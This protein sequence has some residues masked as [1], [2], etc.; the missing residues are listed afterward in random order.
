M[1]EN[2]VLAVFKNFLLAGSLKNKSRTLILVPAAAEQGWGGDLL[3]QSVSM[4]YASRESAVLLTISTLA[5]EPILAS[6]SP[7]KPIVVIFSKSSG[8]LSLL[9]ACGAKA[10]GKSSFLIPQPSSITEMS[11]LPPSSIL[12]CILFAPASMLFSMSSFTTLA[13]LSITS[14]AA[15]IFIIFSSRTTIRGIFN[16]WK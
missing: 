7:L 6:A 9:V 5:T 3:P 2:S 15:I 8:L 16:L 14:P 12:T 4:M 11:F 1:C 10:A 13:G